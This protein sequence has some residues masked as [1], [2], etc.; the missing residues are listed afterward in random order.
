[1]NTLSP[2][3]QLSQIAPITD[4][5]FDDFRDLIFQEAGIHLSE[6]KRAL[7]TGRL[8]K[9]LAALGYRRFGDYYKHL[10]EGRD[11]EE[12]VRMLDCVCTN[13]THF[14]REPQHFQ[15]LETQV[16]PQW[17]AQGRAGGAPYHIH[18]WSAACSTGEEPYTLAMVLLK[19]FPFGSGWKVSVL[20]TDLSTRV[21]AQ[22]RQGV[23]PV[24]KSSEIP[25]E[26]L[27]EYMWRGVNEDEGKMM[28]G[29]ELRRVV[30]FARLNLMRNDPAPG[31]PFDLIFC[32]NVMI[33]FNLEGK[34]QV[35]QRLLR[36]M[37]PQGY[38]FSGHSESLA[39]VAPTLKRVS[40]SVYRRPTALR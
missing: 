33:Y 34:K 24:A 27:R 14:F 31:G 11:P 7:L 9:R 32:R 30:R 40:S 21:L 36:Q 12:M 39:E 38:F 5:E 35:V 23:W 17:K 13:E 1:M 16:F 26:H 22:A 15:Y 6:A 19:H 20:G 37:N 28:A 4:R 25:T 3:I 18:V 2:S 10:T 29:P 8:T